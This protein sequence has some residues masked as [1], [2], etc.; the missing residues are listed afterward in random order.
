MKKLLLALAFVSIGSAAS[1]Q[2]TNVEAPSK[3]VVATNPFWNNW[4]IQVGVDMTVQ[5]PTKTSLN[6]MWHDGRSYGINLS[7]G[8][9]FSPEIGG[10]LKI[11]WENGIL[12]NDH[13][14]VTPHHHAGGYAGVYYDNLFN[15]SNIF[16]GYN[17]DRIWN[18]SVFPRLGVIRNFDNAS[19]HPALGVGV[20]SS[21]K[22]SK[23]ISIY[24][25]A[26]YTFTDDDFIGNVT[27]NG[28]VK[29]VNG[30]LSIDLG[31]TFNLGKSTW[32][33]AVTVEQYNALAK[34][35]EESLARLRADLERERTVNADLRKQ[36][37]K[38]PRTTASTAVAQAETISTPVSVFFNIDS[39]KLNSKKDIIN[40]EAIAK[41]AKASGL[42][43]VITGAADSKTGSS[44]YNKTLSEARAKAVADELVNLGVSRGN[45][46]IRGVGGVN[47]V[48][49]YS[50]NR[51]AIVELK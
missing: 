26:A 2:I 46:E 51:R 49:P 33:K 38:A 50:L 21:W 41:T 32:S 22:L 30:M 11:N 8:K 19:Y 35:G 48:T 29:D 36:L 4:F 7:A 9:W 42:K 43:V 10:R 12:E 47:D 3:Y 15:L 13:N 23:L 14:I 1:A 37:A 16:C 34:S 25:G 20:E 18:V 40:L 27:G 45:I 5:M 39:S 6:D 44:A 28:F 24:A 17:A 31:V